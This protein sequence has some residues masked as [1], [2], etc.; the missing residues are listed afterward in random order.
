MSTSAAINIRLVDGEM[1]NLLFFGVDPGLAVDGWDW[2]CVLFPRENRFNTLPPD[3]AA[4]CCCYYA[5]RIGRHPLAPPFLHARAYDTLL[6]YPW[7]ELTGTQEFFCVEMCHCARADSLFSEEIADS[8]ATLALKYSCGPLHSRKCIVLSMVESSHQLPGVTVQS[9]GSGSSG[10]AFLIRSGETC[11]MLDCGVGIRTVKRSLKEHDLLVSDLAAVLIT[12]E[13][14]DHIRSLSMVTGTD[15]PIISTLGTARRGNVPPPQWEQIDFQQPLQVGA[16]TVWAI[17]VQHDAAEP[18]GYLLETEGTR[19]SIFTD[20]GSWHDRLAAPI[21]ASDLIVLESNHDLEMLKRGPYPAHLK[22][23]VASNRGH[24]SNFDCGQSLGATLRTV[25]QQPEIWLAHLSDTNNEPAV[26]EME[27]RHALQ[28]ND[29][30]LPVTPLP[31]TSPGP[32]WKP[33]AVGGGGSSWQPSPVLGSAT[34][35]TLEYPLP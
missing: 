34:Q 35:L 33:G 23:R 15:I 31:R 9:L 25:R 12:H 16:I 3:P 2:L 22:S 5:D 13:H 21:A 1:P 18:C 11:I 20:L 17:Q 29:L 32:I 19:I 14:T 26:A 30:M 7:S 24:L 6:S 10:N 8:S 4:G 27:T 28:A